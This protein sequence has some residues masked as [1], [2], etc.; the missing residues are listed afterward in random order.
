[1][2]ITKKTRIFIGILVVFLV[3]CNRN[4]PENPEINLQDATAPKATVNLNTEST[5]T[6]EYKDQWTAD[7]GLVEFKN[8]LLNAL[9]TG[10]QDLV[11]S[12]FSSTIE[13]N[14]GVSTGPV[15]VTELWGLDGSTEKLA[16]LK[17]LLEQML[18]SGGCLVKQ[19]EEPLFIAPFYNCLSQ[20]ELATCESGEC[21]V[22]GSD[23]IPL[24]EK[25]KN[26]S[27]TVGLLTEREIVTVLQDT[28]CNSEF[29]NCVWRKIQKNNGL[30]GYVPYSK[31]L[32]KADG[33]LRLTKESSTWKIQILRTRSILIDDI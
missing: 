1:M 27:K 23:T 28:L 32:T 7:S 16:P 9:A 26:E 31:V 2:E 10:N 14:P 5:P 33:Y 20:E 25:P 30:T 11:L 4:K 3:G 19:S 12:S 29:E 15:G 24:L 17:V 22:I 8:S 21:G 18:S 6:C 13:F